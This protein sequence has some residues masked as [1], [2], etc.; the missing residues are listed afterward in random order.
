[1]T[2]LALMACLR[3]E[4]GIELEMA[5]DG[6]AVAMTGLASTDEDF[7]RLQTALEA[8]DKKLAFG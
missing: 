8:V 7:Y 1:M 4:H 2:G 5:R 3:E 6:Y